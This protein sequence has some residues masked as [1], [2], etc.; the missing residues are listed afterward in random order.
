MKSILLLSLLIFFS[1]CSKNLFDANEQFNKEKIVQIEKLNGSITKTANI[2]Q[3]PNY[4]EVI[5][6]VKEV[7]V[8]SIGIPFNEIHES[9]NF[10]S[11]L[12][13]DDTEYD[14][15]IKNLL[16]F[17][18]INSQPQGINTVLGL[19]NFIVSEKEY[20][21]KYYN[22]NGLLNLTEE[23]KALVEVPENIKS[24]LPSGH[25]LYTLAG[26]ILH[27]KE[28]IINCKQL[29]FT[30]DVPNGNFQGSSPLDP[31]YGW[32]F[33]LETK[34]D[35]DGS[36]LPKFTGKLTCITS[37]MQ[38]GQL[39]SSIKKRITIDISFNQ[40]GGGLNLDQISNTP[41]AVSISSV[42]SDTFPHT[43]IDPN[44]NTS[45]RSRVIRVLTDKFQTT[46][47]LPTTITE[48]MSFSNDLGFEDLDFEDMII[49]IED[50]FNVEIQD[51]E[52]EKITT[53]R[54]LLNFLDQKLL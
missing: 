15:F 9:T 34:I 7:L 17:Y 47:N 21:T 2:V 53:V 24:L 51:E 20:K 11:D 30:L 40:P 39:I 4:H 37:K 41:V 13:M 35:E 6:K 27:N 43:P 48:E 54:H 36:S 22:Y 26:S 25:F 1:G 5:S 14:R 29:G 33:Y 8:S 44:Q 32:F 50:E 28:N 46:L 42:S 3:G 12:S 18:A 49:A 19:V 38:N 16:T 52:K 23:I 31:I 10:F 45:I